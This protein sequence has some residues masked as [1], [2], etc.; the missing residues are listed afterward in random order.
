MSID[1]MMFVDA[2]LAA[3]EIARV[4]VPGGRLVMTSP[5]SLVAPFFPTIVRDYRPIFERVGFRTTCHEV[6]AGHGDRQQ[7]L[8][9]ALEDRADRLRAEMGEAA[10]NLLAEARNTLARA[11]LGTSRVRQVLFVAELDL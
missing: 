10:E 2:E 4:L 7:A 6:Q 9:Q 3:R 1:A 11:K 8:Y 5:E